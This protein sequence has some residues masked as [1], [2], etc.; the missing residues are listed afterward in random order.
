MPTR[1]VDRKLYMIDEEAVLG[2]SGT[3]NSLAY[4][5]HEI[6]KH[7]HNSERV[8]GNNTWMTE[9]YPVK[10]TVTGGNNAWGTELMLYAGDTLE[11]G[12]IVK[13][14]DL[15]TLYIASVSTQDVIS[16]LEFLYGTSGPAITPVV[17][18]NGNDDFTLVGHG[19]VN[20]DK[21]IFNSVTTTTGI[22][23][24]TVY[25]V[26]QV[27]TG[28]AGHFQV[29]LTS[30]GAAVVLG[31]GDGTCSISKL[32]QTSLT[33]TFVSK[34]A[35][36]S[37]VDPYKMMAPRVTC[38]TKIFVRAKSFAGS[39]IAIGFLLGLHVYPA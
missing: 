30:G 35:T 28:G 5:V 29:S 12:D 27:G 17:T 38:N 36:A 10:F 16:V 33:K 1:P 8:F 2:L 31:T 14:F 13:K 24:N 15:N 23:A 19:L 11:S 7:F 25:Y 6:E 22:S 26:I 34:S 32:T 37:S 4:R 18:S 21:V 39:T 9:D 20:G 3:V